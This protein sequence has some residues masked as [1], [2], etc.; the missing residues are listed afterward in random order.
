M[1][2]LKGFAGLVVILAAVS[3][4][5]L[6]CCRCLSPG[7]QRSGDRVFR[8]PQRRGSG[9]WAGLRERVEMAIK[10]INAAGGITVGGE[11]Y[12]FKLVKLDDRVDPTEAVNNSRKLLDQYKAP[13]VFNP[14][15]NTLAAMARI[16]QEKGHEFLLMAYT[17]TPKVIE[18]GNNLLVAIPPPFTVYVKSF[19]DLAW[20]KGWRKAAMVVTLG[21][22]RG[23][24][25]ASFQ[26]GTGRRKA[27]RSPRTNR[28][29]TTLRR[30]F[31]PS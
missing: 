6:A 29:I 24:V 8:A 16:N 11:K 15:F 26:G 27:A 23:R 31:P 1:R 5:G 7:G 22:V 20:K 28:P 3:G 14:V 19:S 12:L 10:E 18:M 17:S 4:V 25:A 2:Y 9:I 30:T 13:A 21:A